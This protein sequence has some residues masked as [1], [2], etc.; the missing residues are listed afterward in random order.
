MI[1]WGAP[2]RRPQLQFC[3]QAKSSSLIVITKKNRKGPLDEPKNLCVVNIY[4]E[5]FLPE[6]QAQYFGLGP[7]FRHVVPGAD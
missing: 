3:T 1:F 2:A 6:L 7:D 5:P 4:E